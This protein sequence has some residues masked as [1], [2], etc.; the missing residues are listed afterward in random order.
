MEKT[1]VLEK[2]G[3]DFWK[4]CNE[5]KNSDLENFRLFGNISKKISVEITTHEYSGKLKPFYVANNNIKLVCSYIDNYCYRPAT[6]K[7]NGKKV[8]YE[9][10]YKDVEKT[11]ACKPTK[12][13]VLNKIN[14]IFGT[15]F[16]K[17]QIVE[18]LEG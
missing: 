15:D 6:T 17:M 2:R 4:D 3:C 5:R 16:E 12:K 14:E 8:I 11:G 13:D 1:L 9:E 18:N 7:K 10:C